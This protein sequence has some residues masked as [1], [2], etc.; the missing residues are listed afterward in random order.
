M[1]TAARIGGAPIAH[2]AIPRSAIDPERRQRDQ[3]QQPR[4]GDSPRTPRHQHDGGHHG[5]EVHRPDHRERRCRLPLG[6]EPADLRV[7]RERQRVRPGACAERRDQRGERASATSTARSRR[8]AARRATRSSSSTTASERRREHEAA[9]QVRPGEGDDRHEPHRQRP[10]RPPGHDRPRRRRS[11]ASRAA[12]AGGPSRPA[13]TRKPDERE[14]G[15]DPH[16]PA[17]AASGDVDQPHDGADE[18]RPDD[19]QPRPADGVVERRRTAPG[20][21]TAGS[22]TAAPAT[23]N[24]NGSVRSTAPSA[25]IS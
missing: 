9:V 4:P 2:Q 22:A 19:R 6:H 14:T 11:R 23:V 10:P 24:V 25:S 5:G 20:R 13:A 7:H 17:P 12:A 3:P 21:P 18:D 1:T 15:R 8:T 16:R